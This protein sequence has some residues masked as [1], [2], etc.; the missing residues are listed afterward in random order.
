MSVVRHLVVSVVAVCAVVPAIAAE[1]P[2]AML[3]GAAFNTPSKA[4]ATAMVNAA[5]ASL[6]RTLAANPQDRDAQ[7]QRGIGLGYRGQL[8]R[9]VGDARASR[10]AL[11][12]FAQANPND[13]DAYIALGGWHVSVLDTVG[14]FIGG[15]VLGANRRTGLTALDRAVR[16]GGNR[17]FFPAYAGL[18][19]ISTDKDDTQA[20]ALLDRA[21]RGETPTEVDRITKAAA[22]RVAARLRAGDSAGASALAAQLRPFGRAN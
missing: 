14:G 18:M 17:A 2:R 7:L 8:T 11:T 3:V 9:S 16:L 1:T 6:D 15:T 20:L 12:R 4:Q 22:V 5:L 10:A 21:A 13:P 19:R